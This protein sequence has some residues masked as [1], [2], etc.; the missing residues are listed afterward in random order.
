M[1]IEA[2]VS[3]FNEAFRKDYGFDDV[4]EEV[5]NDNCYCFNLMNMLGLYGA[6]AVVQ[7][8]KLFGMI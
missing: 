5:T 1:L 7:I 6:W 8:L 3:K 4:T 2:T